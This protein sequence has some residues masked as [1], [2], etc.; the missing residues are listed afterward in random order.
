MDVDEGAGARGTRRSKRA[1][2]GTKGAQAVKTTR[3]GRV[4]MPTKRRGSL[5]IVENLDLSGVV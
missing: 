4:L 3:S 5:L 2:M 1:A